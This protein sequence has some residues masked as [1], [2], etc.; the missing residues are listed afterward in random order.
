VNEGHY[1]Q[2]YISEF[3]CNLIPE[4]YIREAM[5]L[6]PEKSAVF[7]VVFDTDEMLYE[8]TRKPYLIKLCTVIH[9]KINK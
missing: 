6:P 3:R 5:D 9:S 8:F 4:D 2:C 1:K 7:V